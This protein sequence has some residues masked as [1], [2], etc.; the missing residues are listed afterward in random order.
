MVNMKDPN[1]FQCDNFQC[2]KFL[3]AMVKQN[4][5]P[6]RQF[7]RSAFIVQ[8][9]DNDARFTLW[10]KV[11]IFIILSGKEDIPI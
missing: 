2:R 7:Q 11:Q 8:T 9:N 6:F 10:L 4:R 1:E 5:K 3:C